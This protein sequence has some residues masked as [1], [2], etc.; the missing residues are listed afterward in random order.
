[1]RVLSNKFMGTN[2]ALL[3]AARVQSSIDKLCHVEMGSRYHQTLSRF[4]NHLNGSV[5]ILR[6]HHFVSV[7]AFPK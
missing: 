6:R 5:V 3:T 2:L 4:R 1:M 7:V